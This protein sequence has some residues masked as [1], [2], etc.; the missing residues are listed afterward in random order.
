MI[1]TL[2]RNNSDNRKLDKDLTQ[3]SVKDCKLKGNCSILRPVLLVSSGTLNFN[4]LEIEEFGR[5]YYVRD[6]TTITDDLIEI[7]CEIDVLMSYREQI[8]NTTAIIGRNENAYN[9]YIP[10]TKIGVDSRTDVIAKE[11]PNGLQ[12]QALYCYTL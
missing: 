7:S 11:F 6:I 10:D 9:M 12:T 2:F 3:V 4:Y 8:K 5:F 1:V